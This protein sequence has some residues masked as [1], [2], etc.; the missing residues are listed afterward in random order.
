[1]IQILHSDQNFSGPLAVGVV[2]SL[3][4]LHSKCNNNQED[5]PKKKSNGQ[6]MQTL[7]KLFKIKQWLSGFHLST[8]NNA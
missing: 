1:M 6:N 4:A 3:R 2:P 7:T 5:T 8:R